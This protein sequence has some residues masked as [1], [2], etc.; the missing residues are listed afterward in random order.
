VIH[1]KHAEGEE[2]VGNKWRCHWQQEKDDN[3]VKHCDAGSLTC[4]VQHQ[5]KEKAEGTCQPPQIVY[6]EALC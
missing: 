5:W 1:Q 6:Q 2:G 3:N 4:W